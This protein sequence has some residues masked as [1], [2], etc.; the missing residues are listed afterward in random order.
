M[1]DYADFF[2]GSHSS[3]AQLDLIEVTHRDFSK[4]YRIVRNHTS[5]VT[6]TLETGAQATFDYYPLRI[7]QLGTRETLDYGVSVDLGDLGEIIPAEVDRVRLAGGMLIKP[8]LIYRTYRS[9]D[10]TRPMFGPVTL[11]M[12][13]INTERTGATFEA[14]APLLNVNRTGEVYSLE[15][16]PMLRGLV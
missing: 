12:R 8:K 15:R 3:V 2:L 7:R 5:G 1:T 14:S 4:V 16:F 10:L 13:E 6:V 11:E 9:D